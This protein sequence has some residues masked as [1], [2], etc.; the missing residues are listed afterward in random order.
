VHGGSA[1]LLP[2]FTSVA[3]AHNTNTWLLRC[4]DDEVVTDNRD[5]TRAYASETS[6]GSH[7]FA[8]V[9]LVQVNKSIVRANDD[10]LAIEAERERSDLKK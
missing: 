9:G 10:R 7:K 6:D 3:R 4:C 8:T 5:L 1:T 2:Y